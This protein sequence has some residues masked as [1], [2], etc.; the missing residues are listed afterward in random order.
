MTGFECGYCNKADIKSRALV[1][2]GDSSYD[3]DIV[4]AGQE[5][6]RFI[7]DKL[8][9][10]IS[11][12]KQTLVLKEADY[13]NCASTDVGKPVRDDDVKVGILF[14]YNNDTRT[15]I[16]LCDSSV[17]KIATNSEVEVYGGYGSGV[18]SA[19]STKPAE[20][21]EPFV[22]YQ[23]PLTD[24]TAKVPDEITAIC[25][26]LGTGIFKRRQMPQSMD[27]GWWAQGIKKLEE[28]IKSTFH[29]GVTVFV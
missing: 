13:V 19:D 17:A 10:Y 12:N 9:P 16:V 21:Q 8:R 22:F 3:T 26:D 20:A 14:D 6:S 18:A 11:P 24:D 27:V 5:A 4:A 25:A 23:V 29:K 28:F 7:D 15:W 2:T 1:A